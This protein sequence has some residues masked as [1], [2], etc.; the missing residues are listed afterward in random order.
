[1]Q[2]RR[3]R[4]LGLDL[5][6]VTEAAAL[7]AGQWMGRGEG[8]AADVAAA[9]AMR[10]L[11]DTLPMDGRIVL[12]KEGRVGREGPLDAGTPL[13][14]GDGP[15]VDIVVDAI[16]GR[17][18][19]AAGKSGAI[20]VAA[21]APRGTFWGH[22]AAIYMEK[23]VV[24]S[25]AA[26]CLVDECLDAPAG[27]TLALVGRVMKKPIRDLVVVLLDRPRH[28]DLIA[29]IREAGARVMLLPEGDISA[30]I[31]AA[32]ADGPADVMM[33][34]GGAVEG[35]LAACAVKIY[36]G[37]M[38]CRLAPRSDEEREAVLA[39]GLD[40]TRILS[41]NDLVPVDDAFFAATGVTGGAL[42]PAINFRSDRAETQ[43]ILL[44][45]ETRT[46]RVIHTEHLYEREGE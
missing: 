17:K 39:A 11:L 21:S 9:Q 41:E 40:L 25:E 5:V 19:V 15:E 16:D 34:I 38:R 6:R 26:G 45:G 33:G 13:G 32:K 37:A 36:G 35:V 4:N 46:R 1:M 44:R 30:A 24:N 28:Q 3:Q 23:L 22:S 27:W 14:T 2:L 18:L 12:G 10:E 42:L 29:E 43:S 31:L 20:S 8:E 7:V